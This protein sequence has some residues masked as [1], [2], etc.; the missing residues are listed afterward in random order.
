[1]DVGRLVHGSNV[2]NLERRAWSKRRWRRRGGSVEGTPVVCVRRMRTWRLISRR[3][4]FVPY[5]FELQTTWQ[6]TSTKSQHC[7]LE[8]T[9]KMCL[10]SSCTRHFRPVASVFSIVFYCSKKRWNINRR[11]HRNDVA[12]KC[13]LLAICMRPSMVYFENMIWQRVVEEHPHSALSCS[14]NP[15]TRLQ[16]LYSLLLGGSVPSKCSV[17][18]AKSENSKCFDRLTKLR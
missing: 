3:R 2:R 12:F 6:H 18:P 1:M 9:K 8:Q 4:T 10:F 13:S 7:D 11:I 15:L 16:L 14:F 17:R 5:S